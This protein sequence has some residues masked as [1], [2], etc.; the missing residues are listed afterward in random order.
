MPYTLV[1]LVNVE[2]S[3]QSS[4]SYIGS[5]TELEKLV[6]IYKIDELIY[7]ADSLS[8]KEIIASMESLNN[9]GVDFKIVPQNSQFIIGSNSKNEPGDYYSFE[10]IFALNSRENKFNKRFFDVVS[11]AILIVTLPLNFWFVRKTSTYFSN[12]FQVLSGKK[13]WVGYSK[14]IG[15]SVENLPKLPLNVLSPLD[16]LPVSEIDDSTKQRLNFIYARDYT[17]Y[18]DIAVFIKGFNKL[19]S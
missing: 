3:T 17:V 4:A 6:G 7:C 10:T 12:L 19:G 15:K 5:F 18:S 1:G 2:N 9:T 16:E 14:S 11:S 13:T 8:N